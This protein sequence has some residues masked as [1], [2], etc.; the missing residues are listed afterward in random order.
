MKK[1]KKAI[2]IL[3]TLL[4]VVGMMGTFSFAKTS[5]EDAGNG[6]I[7]IDKST[8]QAD[9]AYSLYKIFD[10]T[11]N[12]ADGKEDSE[13]N[14]AYTI[15]KTTYEG[16]P[17]KTV[18][19]EYFEVS[20]KAEPYSVKE[21]A[22]FSAAAFA[23]ALEEIE[24]KGDAIKTETGKAGTDVVFSDLALGYYFVTTESGALCNLVTTDK[25]VTIYDKNDKPNIEKKVEGK[26]SVSKDIGSTINFTIDAKLPA[27]VTGYSSYTYKITDTMSDGLTYNSEAKVTIKDGQNTVPDEDY[28][29]EESGNGFVVTMNKNQV[30]KYL[31]KTLVISYSATVNENAV[32]VNNNTAKLEYSNDPN[33]EESTE[34]GNEKVVY[35]Y[36]GAI[37]IDKTD[38]KK[39]SLAGAKFVLKN[40]EGKFYK[41][42]L[43]ENAETPAI[44]D[45]K[46]NATNVEWVDDQDSATVITTD[47]EGLAY[48]VGLAAGKYSLIETEA[49]DGYNILT[50]PVEITI[51]DKTEGE[52][53]TNTLVTTDQSVVNYTGQELPETGGIGTTI[54][55]L[56]G[57]LLVIGAG[58]VYVTRRRMH[59]EK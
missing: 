31:N 52:N 14:Y 59:S 16:S 33:N 25:E 55:Y 8:V 50:S 13:G 26:T 28:T 57:A 39:N 36:T 37:K 42:A 27:T 47:A 17:F 46:G 51:T 12:V 58:V 38:S 49:P 11:Y 6:K 21:K 3:L 22:N 7:T 15:D 41:A 43:K 5:T 35:V 30:E 2:S 45:G 54:F 10:V 29:Y 19:D 56:L 48:F 18:I 4:M 20:I 34:T 53:V 23:N 40:A 24:E 32:S 1:T 44:A 9:K